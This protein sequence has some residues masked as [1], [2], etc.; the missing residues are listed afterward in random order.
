METQ[1]SATTL[2]AEIRRLR[3][4]IEWINEHA[5]FTNDEWPVW[6]QLQDHPEPWL[7]EDA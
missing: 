2:E 6:E 4:L 1:L 5:S 7:S 3:W